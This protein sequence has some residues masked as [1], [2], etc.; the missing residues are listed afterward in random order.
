MPGKPG[1][2]G[3]RQHR[4]R[5]GLLFNQHNLCNIDSFEVVSL[6]SMF[7]FYYCSRLKVFQFLFFIVSEISNVGNLSVCRPLE[8]I[9]QTLLLQPHW[10]LFRF[11]CVCVCACVCVRAF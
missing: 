8:E 2:R 10:V 7:D 11:V 4:G 9:S 5:V 1:A 3:Q 6:L